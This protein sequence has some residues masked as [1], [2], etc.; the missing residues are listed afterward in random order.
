MSGKK[1]TYEIAAYILR[2]AEYT[3]NT[4]SGVQKL[5]VGSAK[6]EK[7][8]NMRIV[9]F[10]W[11]DLRATQNANNCVLFQF[12]RKYFRLLFKL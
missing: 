3:A 9:C 2:K 7:R 8:L 12:K 1:F 4:E 10:F 6:K 11:T 5:R